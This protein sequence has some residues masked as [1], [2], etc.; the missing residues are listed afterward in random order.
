MGIRDEK[1][2]ILPDRY[3]TIQLKVVLVFYFVGVRD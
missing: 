3:T 1:H 2:T